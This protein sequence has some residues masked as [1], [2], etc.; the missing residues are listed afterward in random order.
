MFYYAPLSHYQLGSPPLAGQ[1]YNP[2]PPRFDPDYGAQVSCA[3]GGQSLIWPLVNS[4][5]TGYEGDFTFSF[6]IP[7]TAVNPQDIT[8]RAYLST[9]A[10]TTPYITNI[11]TRSKPQTFKT[12][13]TGF[14]GWV[15]SDPNSAT[16]RLL[17]GVPI[18]LSDCGSNILKQVTTDS[19]GYYAFPVGSATAQQNVCIA[20][21]GP[22]PAVYDGS[23]YGGYAPNGGYNTHCDV[24]FSRCSGYNFTMNPL[25]QPLPSGKSSNPGSGTPVV[26][27]QAMSFNTWAVNQYDNNTGGGVHQAQL[28]DEVPLNIDPGSV[29]S[30]SA[31]LSAWGT[32]AT[33]NSPPAG[34]SVAQSFVCN[35]VNN[36][37][38]YGYGNNHVGSYR[39]GYSPP[40]GSTPGY[41]YVIMS[42]MPAYSQVNLS[43]AGSVKSAQYV[44]VFPTNGAYC[45]NGSVDFSN[46]SSVFGGPLSTSGCQ[47]FS[48]G[49]QGVSNFAYTFIGDDPTQYNSNSTYNPIP[50]QLNCIGKDTTAQTQRPELGFTSGA[51]G[52][53][54]P[55][56]PNKWVYTPGATAYGSAQF[57]ILTAP[58]FKGPIYYSVYDQDAGVP[59]DPA[60]QNTS[61]YTGGSNNNGAAQGAA[62]NQ[63]LLWATEDSVLS[64]TDGTGHQPY[65]F[66]VAFQDQ[67]V[68]HQAGN[69]VR[70]CWPQY[71]TP[72]YPINCVTGSMQAVTQQSITNP[73]VAA[74]NGDIHAGGGPDNGTCGTLTGQTNPR[75]TQN[76]GATGQYFVTATG[77]LS[78][79]PLKQQFFVSSSGTT[80]SN[81][82]TTYGVVCRPDIVTSTE[83]YA[84]SHGG[85]VPYTSSIWS[86]QAALDGKVVE[87]FGD[88][89]IPA[90]TVISSRW[91]LLVHNSN[92][93]ITGNGTVKVANATLNGQPEA[94]HASFGV[95]IDNGSMFIDKGISEV[96]GFYFVAPNSATGDGGRINTCAAPNGIQTLTYGA[97]GQPQY[98]V[99]DCIN[100]LTVKGLMMANAFRLNRTTTPGGGAT[101]PAEYVQFDDRLFTATPP[102]FSTL[103]QTYIPPIYL[104]DT[105]SRY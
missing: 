55:A 66:N 38:W 58:D 40:S 94:Q 48:A 21:A 59:L 12:D 53:T 86:N 23:P 2:G 65:T 75:T 43:W 84:A 83:N 47:D 42:N 62:P 85:T 60:L 95:V 61:G 52:T 64:P 87:A 7:T 71:W 99:G 16:N 11:Y 102:G 41:V 74:S 17:G 27:G 29:N 49:L 36:N 24:P 96:D 18:N 30:V 45:S 73:F 57:R 39:C 50:G 78:G 5:H 32:S 76:N 72:G 93:N 70:A 100:P 25:Q 35:G 20:P 14:E 91:T 89:T 103:S 81:G 88:V 63:W 68:G 6:T 28:D 46:A 77:S 15:Q 44:G 79:D 69:G 56:P 3:D 105:N 101:N 104:P 13:P 98:T 1:S 67:G 9:D 8:V 54:V 90:G 92:V 26:P 33:Q 37:F 19:S 82:A 31:S 97:G 4:N 80:Q 34:W 22:F 10:G 51:C